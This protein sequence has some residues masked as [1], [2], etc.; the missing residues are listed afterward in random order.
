MMYHMTS[1]VIHPLQLIFLKAAL[2]DI[3]LISELLSTKENW[4]TDALSR[5]QIDKV[6]NLF[7]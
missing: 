1:S 2:N 5:F 6:A 4:I 3:E 7:Q